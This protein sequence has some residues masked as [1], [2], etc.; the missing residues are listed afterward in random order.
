MDRVDR[1][2]VRVMALRALDAQTGASATEWLKPSVD[3]EA[4]PVIADDVV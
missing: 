4:A 2:S 3:I 1:S